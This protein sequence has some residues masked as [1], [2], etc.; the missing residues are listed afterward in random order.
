MAGHH[1][2]EVLNLST[3]DIWD[4]LIVVVKGCPA[5]CAMFRSISA[6]GVPVAS[7]L[8]T[9]RSVSRYFQMS[10]DEQIVQPQ[11]NPPRGN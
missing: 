10:P 1:R 11:N 2:T 9:T 8:A 5:L 6:H 4:Q 7:L 3:T